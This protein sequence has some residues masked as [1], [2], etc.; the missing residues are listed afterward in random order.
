[1]TRDEIETMI[2]PLLRN[3]YDIDDIMKAIDEYA[4]EMV[5]GALETTDMDTY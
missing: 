3:E 5:M 4:D 2:Y 1:M